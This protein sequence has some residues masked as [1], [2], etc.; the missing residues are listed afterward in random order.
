MQTLTLETSVKFHSEITLEEGLFD[1]TLHAYATAVW[2]YDALLPEVWLTKLY[3]VIPPQ[4][5]FAVAAKEAA[6]T[7]VSFDT[8][9]GACDALKVTRETPVVALGGGAVCDAVAFFASTYLRGVPLILVPTTLLAMVDASIGGKTALNTTYKNRIGTFYPAQHIVIDPLFLTT[10]S[11]ELK[12]EGYSE[13]IKI[14]AVFDRAFFEALEANTVSQTQII[15]RAIRLKCA[16]VED[17]LSDRGHRLLLNF[18]HTYGHA[19]ESMHNYRYAHGLCVAAGMIL[20]TQTQREIVKR[21]KTLLQH[22]GAFEPI[23]FDRSALIEALYGDKK[24]ADSSLTVVRLK[25]LGHG[26]LETLPLEHFITEVPH[27]YEEDTL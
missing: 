8:L 14:A 26:V 22:Y 10:L 23:P 4:R 6:K 9:V 17:D 1:Q 25:A 20:M 15:E 3:A 7:L 11:S 5:R 21:L 12:A 16:C 19:L 2:F 13:I 24:R 27:H 18:G